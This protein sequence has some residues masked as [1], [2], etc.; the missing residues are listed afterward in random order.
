MV[1]KKG[2]VSRSLKAVRAGAGGGGGGGVESHRILGTAD[3]RWSPF[4]S[5]R[6]LIRPWFVK[7][8]HYCLVDRESFPVDSVDIT[9]FR[10]LSTP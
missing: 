2:K 5:F 4:L 10:R 8:T 3:E 1:G 9:T 7:G 6:W